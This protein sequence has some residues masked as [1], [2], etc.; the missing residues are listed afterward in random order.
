MDAI[1][2]IPAEAAPPPEAIRNGPLPAYRALVASGALTQDPSQALA[3]ERLQM[4]WSR[5]R[6]YDPPPRPARPE[7][8]LSRFWRPKPVEDATDYPHGLYLVGEVGRG[9]SMLMDL[10][11]ATTAIERKRR[12]HFHAF[13][14]EVH[15]RLHRA[16]G[17]A[18]PIQHV[19][20]AIAAEAW[21]LCFDEFTVTDIADAMVLGRL[22]EALFKAGVV[23]VATSNRAPDELYEGGLQRDRFLPFIAV[24]KE[25]MDV[26]H[27]DNGRDYRLARLIGR[28]TYYTPAD[29]RA[30]AA[31][32]EIFLEL[33]DGDPGEPSELA[34]KGRHLRVPR[35]AG[36]VARFSFEALC[37]QPLGAA[38]Y[39]AIAE[40]FDTVILAGVP[41]LGVEQRNEARR[42]NT[43]IDALYEARV[44][45][46]MSA[47]G[48]PESLYPDGDGAFE[49]QR[50]VSRLAEMQSAEYR[51]V[52][53]RRHHA[54]ATTGRNPKA[55]DLA[56]IAI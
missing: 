39:L 29:E 40:A 27:L 17:T 6:G 55:P 48:P 7:T 41:R 42:F 26:L 38:D 28:P 47:E 15:D 21:L 54:N 23:I 31:L 12:V 10:F 51:L 20:E 35:Q 49:F 53:R 52:S 9:K 32:D 30:A 43:L 11:F 18:S 24:L 16:S 56:A 45:L 4:T 22:F 46:V 33:T 2:P 36:G 1:A 37:E 14:Q 8:R 5:L 13:M 3:A 25:E 50:T 34:F 19:A 44:Q